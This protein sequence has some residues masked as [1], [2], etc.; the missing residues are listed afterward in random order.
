MKRKISH[1]F[2][3]VLIDESQNWLQGELTK[4][5]DLSRRASLY[6]LLGESYLL[7]KM[8]TKALENFTIAE[9]ILQK[10]PENNEDSITELFS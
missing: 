10:L 1:L 9:D 3:Y 8:S 2:K 4:E 7:Q 5:T 6:Q